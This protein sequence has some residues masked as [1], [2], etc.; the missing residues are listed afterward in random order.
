[1]KSKLLLIGFVAAFA[2]LIISA[3]PANASARD[4]NYHR[5]R[6][7]VMNVN[8]VSHIDR[9]FIR[10]NMIYPRDTIVTPY[11]YNVVRPY[12]VVS[13]YNAGIYRNYNYNYNVPNYIYPGTI[14]LYDRGNPNT[15]LTIVNSLT[16]ANSNNF[17]RVT[18][19]HEVFSRIASDFNS[20]SNMSVMVDTGNNT[21]TFNTW[22]GTI[23]TGD[24]S[25]TLE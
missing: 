7:G 21:V 23:T 22:T 18:V 17:A 24:V 8:R 15:S 12:N 13:P 10:H 1:M 3:A 4:Y 2:G 14:Y 5:D 11:N 6:V 19:N 20:S 9:N 25:I 16:G